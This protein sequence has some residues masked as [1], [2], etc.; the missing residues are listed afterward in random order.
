MVKAWRFGHR[1]GGRPTDH[2]SPTPKGTNQS[3]PCPGLDPSATASR[4][5]K[6]QF[7]QGCF[8]KNR[9]SARPTQQIQAK[10][11]L[12][13]S[14]RSLGSKA[15]MTPVPAKAAWREDC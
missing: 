8:W 6:R 12:I 2:S 14:E 10:G 15:N 11:S 13:C 9:G 4:V 5:I 7:R 3:L 1:W